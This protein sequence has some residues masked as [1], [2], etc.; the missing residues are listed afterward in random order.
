M[1]CVNRECVS[2]NHN[3]RSVNFGTSSVVWSAECI[4]PIDG[5][6]YYMFGNKNGKCP[7]KSTKIK[8]RFNMHTVSENGLQ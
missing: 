4:G 5:N 6:S 8:L 3:I 1:T 7:I 2:I